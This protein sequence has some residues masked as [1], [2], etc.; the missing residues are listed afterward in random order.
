MKHRNIMAVIFFSLITLGI[1]DLFWLVSVKKELNEK[2]SVHTPTLW[3]LFA[4]V[5]LIIV[6][7]IAMVV[8]AGAS[9]GTA[10]AGQTNAA[11][12]IITI[13]FYLV[14]LFAIIPITFYWFFRFSKAVGAYTG[15]ELNTAVTFIL[16]YLLRFIGIAVIQDKFNDMLAGGAAPS[17]QAFAGAAA[18]V[19]GQPTVEQTL[20][21]Q[22]SFAPTGQPTV[23]APTAPAPQATPPALGEP[24]N[25]SQD[26][27]D[28][29]TPPANPTS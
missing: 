1:Y 29:T 27:T 9:S 4:P 25:P 14:V 7:I 12:A 5:L 26:H 19:A 11:A 16:L 22:Q 21:P 13:L 10:L 3:L 8:V 6:G 23:P 24:S 28:P 20:P 17:G 15:G 2:T 18:P